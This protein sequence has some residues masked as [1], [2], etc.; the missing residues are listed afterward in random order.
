MLWLD[1][2]QGLQAL[3]KKRKTI[4]NNENIHLRRSQQGKTQ[5]KNINHYFKTEPIV[6]DEKVQ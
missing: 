3:L 2:L 5:Y 6:N 1:T 4:V